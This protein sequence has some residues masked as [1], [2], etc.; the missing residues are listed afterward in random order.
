M[1]QR[2]K[3]ERGATKVRRGSCL[4]SGVLPHSP[5]SGPRNKVARRTVHHVLLFRA[6]ERFRCVAGVAPVGAQHTADPD[7]SER[8]RSNAVQQ[9]TLLASIADVLRQPRALAAGYHVR[10]TAV[11]DHDALAALYVAVYPRAVVADLHAAQD[12]LTATFR[13][14]YGRLDLPVSP[15]VLD[16]DTLVAA[17]LVVDAA[18]WPATPA[19]PFIIE[20][21]VHPR[22]RRLGLGECA[23]Q[24]AA[25]ALAQ[26]HER[27]VALRVL[28][29]NAPACTLYQ[30]L[31]F[32]Q[33]RP[34]RP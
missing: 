15:V 29:D 11:H 28:S 33:W 32:R 4:K 21:M 17:V 14:E 12:E 31:G 7:A 30:K 13:G 6:D 34:E 27:T 24:W 8:F 25:Q 10:P 22:Y 2:Q 3:A 9:L 16:Q 20:V 26:R 5:R 23:I 1:G 19:G 18:P